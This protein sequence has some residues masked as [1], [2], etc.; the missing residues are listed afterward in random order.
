MV[1]VVVTGAN[2]A[3]HL[4]ILGQILMRLEEH[5]LRLKRDKC[6]FMQPSVEY[7]GYLGATHNSRE[8]GGHR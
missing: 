4:E 1:S 6:S 7:L 5:G 2:N 8:G 3:E